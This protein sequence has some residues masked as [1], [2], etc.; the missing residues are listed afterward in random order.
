MTNLNIDTNQSEKKTIKKI[1]QKKRKN[2]L[3]IFRYMFVGVK[4]R[5]TLKK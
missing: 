3:N 2:N 5:K 1:S 4:G